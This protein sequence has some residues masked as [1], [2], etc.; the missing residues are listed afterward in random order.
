MNYPL[1][2]EVLQKIRNQ[3]MIN[4]TVSPKFYK[5]ISTLVDKYISS[6]GVTPEEPRYLEDGAID[7]IWKPSKQ[8]N[9]HYKLMRSIY[10]ELKLAQ[11]PRFKA[12]IA[13]VAINTCDLSRQAYLPDYQL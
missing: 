6:T 3:L 1:Y 11:N 8:E 13:D 12:F 9:V 5:D 7:P 2:D 10:D 4:Q